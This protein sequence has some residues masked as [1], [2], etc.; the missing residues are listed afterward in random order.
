M[1]ANLAAH[2]VLRKFLDKV[3]VGNENTGLTL[4]VRSLEITTFQDLEVKEPQEVISDWKHLE[5]DLFPVVARTAPAHLLVRDKR[6]VGKGNIRDGR[7]L[8]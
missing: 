4:V 6:T 2:M 5:E 3:L 7:V 8:H 1:D